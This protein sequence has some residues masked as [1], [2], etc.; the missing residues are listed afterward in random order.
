[1]T[2]EDQADP[3]SAQETVLISGDKKEEHIGRYLI[4]GVLGEGAMGVVYKGFDR[5][6]QRH[7]AS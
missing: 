6:I 7:V 2:T 1:V 4:E 3:Q 5:A